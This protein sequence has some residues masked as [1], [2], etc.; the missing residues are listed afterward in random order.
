MKNLFTPIKAAL[1]L[2]AVSL[3]SY[4]IAQC[5]TPVIT[6][7]GNSGPA[8]VG[9]SVTLNAE[10][11]VNGINSSFI[12]VAGIGSNQG[13]REL[14]E[15]FASGDR[16]G[17]IVRI[18]NDQ[19]NVIFAAQPTN[20]AKA[21][22]IKTKYDVLLFTWASAQNGALNWGLIDAYLAIGG[23]VF[24]EDDQNIHRLYDGTSNS[25][26]GQA[27]NGSYGCS[28]QIVSPAPFPALVANGING[29]FSNHHLKVN[30]F[31]SWMKTYIKG[32]AGEHM[33]VAGIHPT[34][35]GRFI[36]QGPDQ[37]YHAVHGAPH[38]STGGNQ[39]LILLNQIDFLA[40]EQT[41]ISWTGPNG[42]TSNEKSPIITNLTAADAGVYTA[43]LT[44]VTGG[45]CF[46]TANTTVVVNSAATPTIT[47]SGTTD[48]CP[49]KT[50]TLTSSTG[51]SYL[52]NNGSTAPSI[53]VSAAGN[54]SV[55]TTGSNGCAA[56]S[57]PVTVNVNT[58]FCNRAPVAVCNSI[59]INADA[60]CSANAAAADFDGGSTDAD[61]DALT[62]SVFPAGPYALGT[63]NV[64]LTVTD[65][66]GASSTCTTTVT[67]VDNTAPSITAP[68][69][70][71]VGEC[72]AVNLGTAVAS[73]N[74]SVTISNDAPSEF[75]VGTTTVTWTATDG[76][77]LTST[78]TQLV[79]VVAKPAPSIT[80][81]KANN[82]YTGLN[83]TTIALGY[84]AQNVTLTAA[85]GISYS[86]SNGST[87]SVITV[88]PT[89]TS[90]YTVTATDQFGCSSTASVTITVIDAR[91]GNKN[92]KVLVCHKTGSASNQWNQIC[93][94]SN[95]VATHL[96]NGS[97]LGACTNNATT[98]T[99]RPAVQEATAKAIMAYPNPSV[100]NF[101]LQMKGFTPGK[102]TI[103]V[104]NI[105]GK[106][107]FTRTVNVSYMMQDE[108]INLN[109][110]SSGIYQIR[111]AGTDGVTTTALT[112]SK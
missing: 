2:L 16:P 3:N 35:G 62:Y 13:N 66:K 12:R 96:A 90:T 58:S 75:A 7:I 24:W 64:T 54:Y 79:T 109:G 45:G 102:V 74:C 65:S 43:K 55:K 89:A 95:A 42:F 71:T 21:A 81:A 4:A 105:L 17:S 11:T 33:A 38:G 36:V 108:T 10:G 106:V 44:N 22:A 9:G 104:V 85:G 52:W 87:S 31:P 25:L 97:Y 93:V 27:Y 78:A 26:Q 28:Y 32:A 47:T 88:S 56:T 100:G 112:I 23:S 69:A 20:A 107:V 49:G 60:A 103:Q 80:A 99:S 8:C 40:A 76:A 57:A 14:D 67:V 1:L 37:D 84:G 83:N 61:G 18:S 91:C 48:L 111:V 110:I 73:D 19:F 70:V 46:T 72:N 92:D 86:W 6:S 34:G 101:N 39:Y 41:G 94:S 53:T 98:R 5:V 82:T 30:S 50:V 77:G 51:T 68:A 29:C 59:T 63:T 15:V